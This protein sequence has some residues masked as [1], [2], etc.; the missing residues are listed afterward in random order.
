M[1]RHRVGSGDGYPHRDR[2]PRSST[3][4]LFGFSAPRPL[5]AS[6]FCTLG[7]PGF[8]LLSFLRIRPLDFL[9]IFA[10]FF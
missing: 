2:A 4:G 10:P 6:S 3:L 9:H 5:H 7:P 8:V 1:I